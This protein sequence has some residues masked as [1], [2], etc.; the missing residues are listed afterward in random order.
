[1]DIETKVKELNEESKQKKHLF[2]T[3]LG[4]LTLLLALIGASFAYFTA[5]I[6]K[7]RGNQSLVLGT[8][9]LEGVTFKSTNNLTL[10]DATP[11]KFVETEYTVTNPNA[12]AKVRY[13]LKVV[14]DINEFTPD[15]GLKQA[16]IKVTGGDLQEERVI[17]FT[18]GENVKEGILVSNKDLSSKESDTYKIKLEFAETN[19][20][21]DANK[22]KSF[23][24]HIEATQTI[25][26][27]S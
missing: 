12:G 16:L 18:D 2:I 13:T 24:A 5:T 6:N 8:T 11:G 1:M 27:E 10:L 9:T 26:V 22:G 19:Q 23:V 14:A 4:V 25:V 7:P 17:D 20:N 3:I 15:G 21:Q